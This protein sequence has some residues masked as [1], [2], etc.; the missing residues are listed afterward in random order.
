[1]FMIGRLGIDI[2]YGVL[3]ISIYVDIIIFFIK[4]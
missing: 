3:V 1:M 2:Y 4:I